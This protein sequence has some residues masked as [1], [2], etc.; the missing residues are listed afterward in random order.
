MEISVSFRSCASEDEIKN[1]FSGYG[2]PSRGI[3]GERT[4][5]VS[6]GT[7]DGWIKKLMM[8]SIVR[9]AEKTAPRSMP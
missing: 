8:R 5:D 2:L 1:L 6:A 3:G 7:E 4:V 9:K